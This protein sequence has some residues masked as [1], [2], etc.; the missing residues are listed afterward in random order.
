MYVEREGKDLGGG[1]GGGA[2]TKRAWHRQIDSDRH[3]YRKT[4]TE[5]ESDRQ[6]NRKKGRH[7][8]RQTDN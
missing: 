7:I 6:T 2:W 5:T 4:D 8:E 3:T 1:G